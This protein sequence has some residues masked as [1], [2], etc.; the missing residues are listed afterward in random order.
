MEYTIQTIAQA[1]EAEF[2]A[3]HLPDGCKINAISIDSRN[4]KNNGQVVFFAIVARVIMVINLLKNSTKL[5]FVILLF[6]TKAFT[7]SHF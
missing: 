3:A 4:I 7:K 2:I 6:P 1:I 5:G